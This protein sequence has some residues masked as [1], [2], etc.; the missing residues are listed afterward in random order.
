MAPAVLDELVAFWR[1]TRIARPTRRWKPIVAPAPGARPP[2]TECV[3][4]AQHGLLPTWPPVH[5]SIGT[6]HGNRRSRH[7]GRRWR[8]RG[9]STPDDRPVD[10]RSGDEVK[11]RTAA[12]AEWMG[13]L[14]AAICRAIFDETILRAVHRRRRS[15][16]RPFELSRRT[17]LSRMRAPAFV[18]QLRPRPELTATANRAVLALARVMACSVRSGQRQRRGGPDP[19]RAIA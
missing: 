2:S 11:I 13:T 5:Q 17:S 1:E 19:S 4:R 18:A 10:H 6:T 16:Q 15:K 7:A 14:P 3:V 9:C 12:A 8:D